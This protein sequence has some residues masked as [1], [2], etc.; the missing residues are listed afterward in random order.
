MFLED[1][2]VLNR[3]TVVV[4]TDCAK[5]DLW[6]EPAYQGMR[7]ALAEAFGDAVPFLLCAKTTWNLT[8]LCVGACV[9]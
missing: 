7:P 9:V 5:E 4:Q 1:S 8:V 6:A 2:E 3:N